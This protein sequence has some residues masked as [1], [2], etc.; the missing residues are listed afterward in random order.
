MNHPLPDMMTNTIG[1]I[2][3]LV[4]V[5]TIIGEPIQ[6]G[7]VT[8]IPVS[9]VKFGFAGGGSD[10]AGK[11]Y[12]ANRQNAFGGGTGGSISISP[13]AF[14]VIRGDNVRMLPIVEPATSAVERL[15]EQLPNLIEQVSGFLSKKGGAEAEE[16]E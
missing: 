3:D 6:T 9:K 2:R 16:A 11:N 4:D 14:L 15:I 7:D 13:V 1:K 8:I 12:P 10:F 5:D